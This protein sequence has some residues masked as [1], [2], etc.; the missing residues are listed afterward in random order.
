MRRTLIRFG[1]AAV[2]AVGTA[3]PAPAFYWIGWPGANTI[4]PPSI[5]PTTER[6]EERPPSP[7][8][9][10]K[11]PPGGGENPP[12][13]NPKGVPEPTTMGIAAIG[14]GGLAFGW[15]KKRRKK[16]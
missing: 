8:G 13:D 6:V 7:G 3:A 5:V 1:L 14:L 16:K 15:W 2:V 12:P 10:T 11:P 4:T 9:D